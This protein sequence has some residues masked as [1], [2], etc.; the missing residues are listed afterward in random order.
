M[1]F[2]FNWLALVQGSTIIRTAEIP[3]NGVATWFNVRYGMEMIPLVTLF[4]GVLVTHRF[5]LLRR[6]TLAI[7]LGLLAFVMV[8]NTFGQLPYVLFDPLH[9]SNVHA[10]IEQKVIGQYLAKHYSGGLMLLSYSPFAPAVFYSALP[11]DDFLT[12]SNGARY[13]AALADPAKANV[14]WILLDPSNV[15]FDPITNA[16]KARPH[17][18][19]GYVLVASFGTAKLYERTSNATANR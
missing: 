1:P 4:L 10:P 9:G 12:D 5:V 6:L 8:T 3:V 7:C 15:D 16:A 13:N 14:T 17:F 11:D 18:L 19:Q 2:A